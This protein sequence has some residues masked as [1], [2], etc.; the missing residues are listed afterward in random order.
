M[1]IN[2]LNLYTLEFLINVLDQISILVG[3]FCKINKRTGTNKHTVGNKEGWN[4][5]GPEKIR[6][7]A[8]FRC[9]IRR[10]FVIFSKTTQ[11]TETLYTSFESSNI[12]LFGAR[13]TR[14][15]FIP[16]DSQN[17]FIKLVLFSLNG[18]WQICLGGHALY[19]WGS[20]EL[21]NR[22]FQWG[23]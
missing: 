4:T 19:H 2:F 3:K 23:I 9:K 22:A 8:I 6:P 21:H 20:K 17:P 15:W 5:L 11:D 13:R 14:A 12:Q 7:I 16:Y 10:F 1:L 18:V